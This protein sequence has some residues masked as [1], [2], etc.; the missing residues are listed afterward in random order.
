[1]LDAAETPLDLEHAVDVA[2][3]MESTLEA[4]ARKQTHTALLSL[5]LDDLMLEGL[6]SR[7]RTL[8]A[9]RIRLDVE[10]NGVDFSLV[11]NEEQL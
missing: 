6:G 10:Q 4:V 1:M 3:A 9:H 2:S 11:H 8:L 5:F 7:E